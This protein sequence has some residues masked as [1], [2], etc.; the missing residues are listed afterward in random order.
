MGNGG[1]IDDQYNSWDANM[2]LTVTN[3]DFQSVAFAPPASCPQAYTP[4]G[5]AC[6][7]PTDMT[8]FAGMASAR[9]ADGSLPV[10]PFLRLAATSKLIDKGTNVGLPYNGAAPDLG[11]F[12]SP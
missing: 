8:C 10:V 9:Q 3:A 7:A 11:C 4:G 1:P 2:N 12:E 5:T 6:C